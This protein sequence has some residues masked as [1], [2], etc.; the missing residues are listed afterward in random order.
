MF[1]RIVANRLYSVLFMKRRNV[2][3]RGS[4]VRAALHWVLLEEAR[5]AVVAGMNQDDY[6]EVR[7]LR[8]QISQFI[9]KI[10]CGYDRIK[11]FI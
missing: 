6:S 2:N 11:D 1:E 7:P 3:A 9:G 5:M 10:K 4:P 8:D